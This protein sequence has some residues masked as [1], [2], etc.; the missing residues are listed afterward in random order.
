MSTPL[1]PP[2]PPPPPENPR[3][4]ISP[5]VLKLRST[6]PKHFY[7]PPKP[8]TVNQS[9]APTGPYFFY[10]TLTDPSMVAEILNLDHEPTFRPAIIQGYECKMWGQYPAL[11]DAS[12]TI[13]EGAV[14][15]VQTAEDGMKLATYETNSYRAESCIISYTDGREPAK[16]VGYTF[17]FVGNMNDLHEGR[18]EL[19]AWLKLMGREVAVERLDDRVSFA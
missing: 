8:T 13:V 6:P 10:G 9:T 4:K 12:D 14:Y 18:F 11:V 3:S 15:Y 16:D 19:R 7:T 2:P 17:K 5:V 1:G